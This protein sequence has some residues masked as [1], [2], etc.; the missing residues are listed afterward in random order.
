MYLALVASL[1]VIR[2]RDIVPFDVV[3]IGLENPLLLTFGV[4]AFGILSGFALVGLDGLIRIFLCSYIVVYMHKLL[5][6]SPLFDIYYFQSLPLKQLRDNYHRLVFDKLSSDLNIQDEKELRKYRWKVTSWLWLDMGAENRSQMDLRYSLSSLFLYMSFITMICLY[7]QTIFAIYHSIQGLG[8]SHFSS[9]FLL[10]LVPIFLYA[11]INLVLNLFSITRSFCKK[12]QGITT[13]KTPEQKHISDNRFPLIRTLSQQIL[14]AS[15]LFILG[16][17]LWIFIFPKTSFVEY[18]DWP[19]WVLFFFLSE[20]FY[21]A[22]CEDFYR[23]IEYYEYLLDRKW[24][25]YRG[26]I[27]Q[28]IKKESSH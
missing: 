24:S 6:S 11:L 10:L 2:F 27:E 26:K 4:L 15:A 18:V 23:F 13:S 1:Y 19:F 5:L 14:I 9:L 8:A 7:V 21:W 16:A 22:G 17:L 12:S 25:E 3:K 28:P 20:A